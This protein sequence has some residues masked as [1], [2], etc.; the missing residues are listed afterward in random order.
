MKF[1]GK[2]LFS[3]TGLVLWVVT[4][5]YAGKI[6]LTTYYPS[7]AGEYTSL[8]SKGAC[9]GACTSSD[10]A[11][12]QLK[13]KGNVAADSVSTTGDVTAATGSV[14]AAK[15]SATGQMVLPVLAST[16]TAPSENGSM[17]IQS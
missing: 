14:T 6:E 12:N 17:W 2:F 11:S 15:V 8:Q 13:V 7:P 1:F 10:V 16:A 9:V 4:N 5:T 3:L